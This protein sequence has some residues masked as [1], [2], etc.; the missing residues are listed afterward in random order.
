MLAVVSPAR[1]ARA[2]TV[3][4]LPLLGAAPL[5]IAAVALAAV[6]ALAAR[7]LVARL[8]RARLGGF[9]GDCLGAVQQASE[10]AF[11]V[12]AAALVGVETAG[13]A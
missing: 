12:A 1:L 7:E 6:P 11:L 9:T 3:G 10:I 4:A 5:G 8:V 13:P 2:A